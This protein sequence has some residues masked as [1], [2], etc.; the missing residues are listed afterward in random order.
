[1]TAPGRP[2]GVTDTA[3]DAGPNPTLFFAVTEI[4]YFVFFT[5]SVIVQVVPEGTVHDFPPGVAVAVKAVIGGPSEEVPSSQ[6]TTALL[7]A[8]VALTFCGLPG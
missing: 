4:E 6:L 8:A 1:V 5:S 7:S 3:V 2:P